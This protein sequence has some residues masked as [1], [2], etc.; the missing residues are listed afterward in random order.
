[1]REYR[2]PFHKSWIFTQILIGVP[3]AI[4]IATVVGLTTGCS[5]WICALV[6]ALTVAALAAIWILGCR[7]IAIDGQAI[8]VI[9]PYLGRCA[10]YKFADID[11]VSF[12]HY[13]IG[14]H[15]TDGK[16]HAFGAHLSFSDE[17]RSGIES[18]L[19]S[20]GVKTNKDINLM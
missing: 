6:A 13:T 7:Y 17:L 5:T 19:N 12:W 10:E 2:L 15:T 14:I 1:M 8:Y 20:K 4:L 18:E 3:G 11:H 9:N 16:R